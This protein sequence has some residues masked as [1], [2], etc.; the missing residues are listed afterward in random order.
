[1]AVGVLVGL[2]CAAFAF[3]LSR[4]VMGIPSLLNCA[5]FSACF[6][7]CGGWWGCSLM[8]AYGRDEPAAPYLF[9]AAEVLLYGLVCY[10]AWTEVRYAF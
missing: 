7:M 6:G 5:G 4:H 3:H 2:A 9:P 1:M 8:F 10:Q